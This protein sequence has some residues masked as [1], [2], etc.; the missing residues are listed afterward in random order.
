MRL[1]LDTATY[2]WLVMDGSQL[3]RNAR[4]LLADPSNQLYLST[5]SAWEIVIK[6]AKGHIELGMP[7]EAFLTHQR[8][9]HWVESLPI[10]EDAVLALRHLPD[11]HQDPFDR[12]LIAQ[13]V[14]EDMTIITSDRL[15]SRYPVAVVW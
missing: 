6:H 4:L 2:I 13:A 5:A 3:S 11:M 1:L 12:L 9:I 8:H 10:T 7:I 14:A 15:I